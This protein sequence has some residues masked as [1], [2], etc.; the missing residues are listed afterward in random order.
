MGGQES[1]TQVPQLGVLH[2]K[3]YYHQG[4]QTGV[5][6]RG[7]AHLPRNTSGSNENGLFEDGSVLFLTRVVPGEPPR[8]LLT[9]IFLSGGLPIVLFKKAYLVF[10]L[11]KKSLCDWTNEELKQNEWPF[12]S[13]HLS[14]PFLTN[15]TYNHTIKIYQ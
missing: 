3:V 8:V 4:D 5:A 2:K 1:T 12:G 6:K 11:D 14:L 7:E 10:N 15:N 13:L 9:F